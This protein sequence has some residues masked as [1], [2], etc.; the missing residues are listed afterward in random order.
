MKAVII[1]A[2]GATGR[3]LLKLL[4]AAEEVEEVVALVR[5][6]LAVTHPKLQA[7]VVDFDRIEDW[8]SHISGDVAFSC[9]GTTLRAAGGKEAQYKVDFGYQY[10]FAQMARANNVRTFVLVSSSGASPKSIVFYSRMKG[11]LEQAVAAL[12]F[13][14]FIVFRP[15]PLVRP[16]TDRAGEKAG[17]AVI[18]FLNKLGLLRNM[19]PL[20]VKDLA[21]LMLRYAMN[22]PP[23]HTILESGRILRELGA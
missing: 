2:T 6:P 15:G 9:L 22:P 4:M 16:D 8:A 19:A 5:K 14:R 17:V 13:E 1:G 11:E 10:A 12:G 7:L 3:E 21:A 23:G 20:A 18:S